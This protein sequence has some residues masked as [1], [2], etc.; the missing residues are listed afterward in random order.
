MERQDLLS[1][2]NKIYSVSEISTEIKTII[3]NKFFQIKVRGEISGLKIQGASGHV[4]FNIKENLSILAAVCWS[5]VFQRIKIDLKDGLDVIITGKLTTY[6]GQS[7]YQ[8]NVEKIELAGAGAWMQILNERKLKLQKEGIFDESHKKPIVSYPSV[9][10]IITS[11]SGSVIR[12]IIH[13]IKERWPCRIIIYSV[14]VQGETSANEVAKAVK[15]FNNWQNSNRPDTIII[16]R[17]GGSIEDL[18][19]FNEE[20]V[21]YSVFNSQIPVI[22]A[23]GHETD[24]SLLDFVSDKRA[25]TPTAAAEFATPVIADLKENQKI[26]S[27]QLTKYINRTIKDKANILNLTLRGLKSDFILSLEQRIDELEERLKNIMPNLLALKAARVNSL[28]VSSIK[29]FIDAKNN[30]ILHQSEYIKIHILNLLDKKELSL[31]SIADLLSSL[32]YKKTLKRGF[33]MARGLNGKIIDSKEKAQA[34]KKFTITFRDGSMN[35][36][37]APQGDN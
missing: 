7:R 31:K 14:T 2:N 4:Y 17:G 10:G 5:S 20:I 35:V 34:S 28:T 1:D 8:I 33:I 6:N 15:E 24:Y 18:W 36:Q 26:Y 23:I 30:I 27:H 13:R 19:P 32:D 22:S 12:D 9:I 37:K 21:I 3:E 16:A 29:H 11:I 25:P